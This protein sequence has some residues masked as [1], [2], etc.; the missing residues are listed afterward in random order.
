MQ[1]SSSDMPLEDFAKRVRFPWYLGRDGDGVKW[2]VELGVKSVA[3]SYPFLDLSIS[4]S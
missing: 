3:C 4:C 1:S 2:F